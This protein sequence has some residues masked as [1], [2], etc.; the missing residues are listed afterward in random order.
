MGTVFFWST[1]LIGKVNIGRATK[2]KPDYVDWNSE[3]KKVVED[4]ICSN[5]Q[6]EYF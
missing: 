4:F 2:I 6:F 3:E 1:E 5:A